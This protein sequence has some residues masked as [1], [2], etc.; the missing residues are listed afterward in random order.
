MESKDLK[1]ARITKPTQKM[2]DDP[3]K[4]TNVVYIPHNKLTEMAK[5]NPRGYLDDCCAI[6]ETIHGPDHAA[7]LKEGVFRFLKTELGWTKN[8]KPCLRHMIVEVRREN[9]L[10]VTDYRIFNGMDLQ[11]TECWLGDKLRKGG[12]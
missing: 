1:I 4:E 7:K 2:I 12:E 6:A 9:G 11:V 3:L 8:H 10:K 5:A